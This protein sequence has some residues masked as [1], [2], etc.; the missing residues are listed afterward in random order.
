M[1]WFSDFVSNPIGATVDCQRDHSGAYCI[2]SGDFAKR[3]DQRCG[4]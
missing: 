2:Y 3:G 1:G 4:R